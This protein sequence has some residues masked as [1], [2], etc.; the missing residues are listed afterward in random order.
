MGGMPAYTCVPELAEACG[1]ALVA[2]GV[3]VARHEMPMKD[4]CGAPLRNSEAQ[5][6]LYRVCTGGVGVDLCFCPD[7][8][9]DA[10]VPFYHALLFPLDR[11]VIPD[12]V[13]QGI[14]SGVRARHPVRTY[15]NLEGYIGRVL[16]ASGAAGQP[17]P[18]RY[19][20]VFHGARPLVDAALDQ[21]NASGCD[22]R[23]IPPDTSVSERHA[24]GL[25]VDE[26]AVVRRAGAKVSLFAGFGID[27]S[28]KDLCP[29]IAVATRG[30]CLPRKRSTGLGDDCDTILQQAGAI[31]LEWAQDGG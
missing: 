17:W 24:L 14:I 28:T 25:A 12:S 4:H 11:N 6:A 30:F 3:S 19:R 1:R 29:Y 8:A 27:P 16:L 26:Q 23:R 5:G 2:G 7:S 22:V 20:S 10:Q 15:I 9:S 13:S 21:L 18:S 31:R